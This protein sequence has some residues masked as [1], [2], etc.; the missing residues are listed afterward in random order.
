MILILAIFVMCIAHVIRVYRWAQFIKIYEKPDAKILVRSLAIGY[1]LNFCLPFKGGDLF[2]AWLAG[3]GMKNGVGF[4]AAT[5]V[6]DR[7]L[8][9]LT[10]G[11][12]F[13]VLKF[14]NIVG[15]ESSDTILFYSSL[16]LMV[17]SGMVLLWYSRKYVKKFL[18][19]VT[20]I[21]NAKLQFIILKFCFSLISSFKDINKIRKGKLLVGTIAMWSMYLL[22]Y[23]LFSRFLSI[24]NDGLIKVVDIFY[25]LFEKDSLLSGN[26]GMSGFYDYGSAGQGGWLA[27]FLLIPVFFLGGVSFIMK[28]HLEEREENNDYLNLIPQLDEKERLAFL[29]LY[30][31]SERSNYVQQYLKINRNILIIN[32]FSAGSNATTMLCMDSNRTFFRKY[33]FG[34]DG[35]KLYEQVLWLQR[36]QTGFPFVKIIKFEKEETFCYYDMDYDSRA[37]GLFSYA[38]SMPRENAWNIIKRLIECLEGTL[39]HYNCKMA[40]I[41]IIDSYIDN[42]VTRNLEKITG[43]NYI[44]NLMGYKEIII[45]GVSYKNLSQ[46]M[47]FF[48]KENLRKVF[49]EDIYSEI[50]GDLT[51]E[52]IIC[53]QKVE[54]EDDFYIIDPNT[55]NIHNSP[56]LDYAKL[57]QSLHGGYEFLMAIK[58][59]EIDQNRINFIFTKS[60]TY[61]YLYQMLNSY[62][63]E[64]FTLNRIKSIYYHEIIHWLRLMPYKIEKNGKRAL[65]FYAGMLIVMNDVDKKF[66]KGGEYY[67]EQ[68][69][70]I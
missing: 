21:F 31:E 4:A 44:K 57:L 25:L 13:L 1:L 59:I 20:S 51:V 14:F 12:I 42:K 22:S 69:S 45:N 5:V 2:R 56:N 30:F 48:D 33:A 26:M 40:D 27:V 65:L 10:V 46:Y 67:Q 29:E 17:L 28:N 55:G 61:A 18:K 11:F 24:S 70:N 35:E 7:Y 16:S 41:D 52:N 47:H 39:Y 32:D 34:A 54:G 36:F 62:M 9:I 15:A 3:R 60:E 58:N 53:V 66:N 63:L 8:D 50:H 64:H 49:R 19:A 23:F 37:V 68:I 43:A 38:H 6:I